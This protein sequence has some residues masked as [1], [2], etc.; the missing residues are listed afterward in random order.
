M[1]EIL[2]G[3]N[4]VTL[5]R[6]LPTPFSLLDVSA[7]TKKTLVVESGVIGTQMVDEQYIRK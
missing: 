2:H 3:L 1:T 5:G 6:Y 7:A 4:L